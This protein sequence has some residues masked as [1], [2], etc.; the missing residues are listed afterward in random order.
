[1]PTTIKILIGGLAVLFKEANHWRVIF[2]CDQKH[3]LKFYYFK[4]GEDSSKSKTLRKK[5]REISIRIEPPR[6][7]GSRPTDENHQDIFNMVGLYAHRDGV[8]LKKPDEMKK[9]ERVDMIIPYTNP[10]TEVP[11][12]LEYEIKIHGS[13]ARP[14][15]M[16][17]VAEIVGA[18]IVLNKGEK[19]IIAGNDSRFPTLPEFPDGG[20]VTYTLRFDNDCGNDCDEDDDFGLYYDL[21]FD[22]KNPALEFRAGRKGSLDNKK[23]LMPDG[24]C[25][26]IIIDPPPG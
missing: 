14:T 11:S 1:M 13:S 22:A 16:P 24:N 6:P 23:L 17:K 2:L 8:K 12:D 3:K 19:L 5:G 10:Y 7:G 25:D 4:D 15:P 18:K 9:M 20:D 26:P 21:M